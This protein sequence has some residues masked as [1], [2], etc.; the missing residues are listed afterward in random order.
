MIFS[1]LA[2]FQQFG[3]SL[4]KTGLGGPFRR[5]S[6]LDAGDRVLAQAVDLDSLCRTYVYTQQFARKNVTQFSLLQA[7]DVTQFTIHLAKQSADTRLLLAHNPGSP[8]S[9]VRLGPTLK[10]ADFGDFT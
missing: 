8:Q 4:T 6:R 2:S 1:R 5:Q 7:N 9:R 3:Y 10:G